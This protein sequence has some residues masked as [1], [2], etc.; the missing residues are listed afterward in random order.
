MSLQEAVDFFDRYNAVFDRLDGDA[1]AALWHT[2]S[3][4]RSS[5]A[6]TW[7]PEREP[8][9]ANMH[10]LCDV[11]R[12]A[13]YAKARHQITTHVPMGADAAFVNVAWTLERAD[14]SVLQRFC[15][16][17]NLQRFASEAG[18]PV[19]VVHCTAYQENIQALKS[20]AV[21]D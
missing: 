6:M 9:R 10:A 2:P 3:G 16:S 21:N 20:H 19:K 7:W 12:N 14:G 4:I 8:M 5:E 17:Y 13:G 18:A 15:T 11:Y 1:V